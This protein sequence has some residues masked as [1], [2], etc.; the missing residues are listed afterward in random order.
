[1]R[2]SL[3]VSAG[4]SKVRRYHRSSSGWSVRFTPESGA[5]GEKG[6]RMRPQAK[7]AGVGALLT[8]AS[9]SSRLSA[10]GRVSP[11]RA[12]RA[13]GSAGSG[14]NAYSHMPLSMV[15]ASRRMVGRGVRAG[16]GRRLPQKRS[17]RPKGSR[18]GRVRVRA[19]TWAALRARFTS[20]MGC[21]RFSMFA[22]PSPAR[23]R[24]MLA[25]V[26]F[27]RGGQAV[28]RARGGSLTLHAPR[29][30]LSVSA[31]RGQGGSRSACGGATGTDGREAR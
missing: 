16:R 28:R 24:P 5:S 10:G 23:E 18:G 3:A 11:V 21:L 2:R 31:G 19:G 25:I 15:Y 29:L 4:G 13:G 30:I 6:T 26:P 1:M 22:P 20:S 14:V 9:A 7:A 8:T 12:L 17:P 27:G